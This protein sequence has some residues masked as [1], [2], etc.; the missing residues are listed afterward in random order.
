MKEATVCSRNILGVPELGEV[1]GVWR[2]PA[3]GVKGED[4]NRAENANPRDC[5]S[6]STREC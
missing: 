5:E 6:E 1:R 2:R 4:W 3:P